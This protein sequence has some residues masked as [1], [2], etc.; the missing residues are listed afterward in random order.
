M[1]KIKILSAL[2]ESG[3]NRKL[4]QCSTNTR[5][6]IFFAELLARIQL[7]P[8]TFTLHLIIV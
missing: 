1:L 2:R 7:S 3:K 6:F 4:T 5:K 8:N